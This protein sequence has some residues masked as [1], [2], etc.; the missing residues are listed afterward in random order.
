MTEAGA[1]AAT[2]VGLLMFGILYAI[3]LGW[4]EQRW[5]FRSEYTWAT[6]VGG[7]AVVLA[8]SLIVV[9]WQHIA[10]LFGSFAAAG[11]PQVVGWMIEGTKRRRQTE[12][13]GR[14]Q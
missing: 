11:V 10:M 4:A 3:G 7:T 9:P 6:V 8:V 14:G 1:L 13:A 2:W 12:E 5:H